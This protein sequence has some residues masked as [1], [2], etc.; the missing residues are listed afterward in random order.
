MPSILLE[1][2]QVVTWRG[3]Y[4]E[5]RNEQSWITP[6]HDIWNDS[7]LGRISQIFVIQLVIHRC[8]N[9]IPA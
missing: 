6:D 9:P 7:D 3:R 5:E 8:F 2:L 1:I 4:L